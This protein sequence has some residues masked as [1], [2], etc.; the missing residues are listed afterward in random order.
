VLLKKTKFADSREQKLA[1]NRRMSITPKD[2]GRP[3][4]DRLLLTVPKQVPVNLKSTLDAE[5]DEIR[6]A[7]TQSMRVHPK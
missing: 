4:F 1:S 5:A 7:W 6:K 3:I 2:A